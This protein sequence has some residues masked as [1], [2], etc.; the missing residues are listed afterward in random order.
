[1]QE[2]VRSL[3]KIATHRRQD[4]G[5]RR[6]FQPLLRLLGLAIIGL[7]LA[8]AA[9]AEAQILDQ[10]I[11]LNIPGSAF[12]PGVTV[13]SRVRPEYE[14]PGIHAGSFI[15]RPSLTE[16]AGYESNVSGA[17]PARGSPLVET[18]AAVQA[19]SNWSRNSLNAGMTVDNFS[20]TQLPKY[21]YTNWT[22]TTDGTYEIGRDVLAGAYSHL[23]LTQTARDLDVPQ[24]D[25]AI[26]FTVNSAR[27]SY[28]AVF[29]RVFVTPAVDVSSYNFTNGT[30]N[31]QPYLQTYRNRVVVAPSV[32]LGY[33]LAP[34][35]NVVFVVRDANA[36][37]ASPTAG[38]ANRN[39]NDVA[40]LTGL[41]FDAD[42]AI[43][44]R[45]LGG[46]EVRTFTSTQYK[47]I[48]APLIEGTAIWTPTGL[49]T[50]T[51]TVTRRIQDSADENTAALT[52][53]ALLLK[54]DHEYLRNVILGAAAG[55][56]F[57][58]YAN[59]GGNQTLYTGGV[60]AT[61]LLNRNMQLTAS[62]NLIGRQ[63]GGTGSLGQ[64]QQ[65]FATNY[66]DNQILLRLRLAL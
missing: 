33:E 44:F 10:Y 62:Y 6:S 55:I 43:R 40:V 63:S 50:V 38:M 22:A 21:S 29:N 28:R 5:V 60:S 66:I 27:V 51:G 15:I 24:L 46:Y 18:N 4:I 2:M 8:L 41:D 49:T 61:Y 58:Q 64:T 3:D 7:V 42:A 34:R 48:Q 59:N 31:G 45:V 52:T 16:S 35:R 23:N 14:A 47:T 53:T 12:E 11:N 57:G 56:S 36:D 17:S 54:V 26:P 19:N 9:P 37:Y 25:Q 20:Y 65:P 30:V 39:Y 32:I 13:A 1:M